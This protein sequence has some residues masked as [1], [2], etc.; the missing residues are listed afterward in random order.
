M[1]PGTYGHV[2]YCTLKLPLWCKTLVPRIHQASNNEKFCENRSESEKGGCVELHPGFMIDNSVLSYIRAVENFRGTTATRRGG[3]MS[4]VAMVIHS[5]Q[6]G[7]SWW[8]L[9][10]HANDGGH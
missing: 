5:R 3:H 9:L 7:V 4:I 6:S 2:F 1:K 10:T 8:R